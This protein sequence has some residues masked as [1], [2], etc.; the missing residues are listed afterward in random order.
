MLQSMECFPKNLL[1]ILTDSY[2]GNSVIYGFDIICSDKILLKK[3]AVKFNS[4]VYLL[5]SDLELS[6]DNYDESLVDA[7]KSNEATVAC[8][9]ALCIGDN[10]RNNRDISTDLLQVV[11]KK[12]I[13]NIRE[14]EIFLANIRIVCNQG[15][16]AYDLIDAAACFYRG[17]NYHP[18]ELTRNG[19][20]NILEEKSNK[21]SLDFI[22]LND[23]YNS[24]YISRK[25]M[26]LYIK[27]CNYVCSELNRKSFMSK[28]VECIKTYH[29]KEYS[30]SLHEYDK[31]AESTE[32]SQ[33]SELTAFIP[34]D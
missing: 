6:S 21:C 1:E 23:L 31:P 34:L 14:D 3:G 10:K 22:I 18:M 8:T 15:I 9:I 24:D 13:D 11:I 20:A 7:F 32:E 29:P 27:Q 25:I 4:L 19:I 26:E 33:T 5:P 12:G 30:T 17:S 28:F 2:S 16:Y